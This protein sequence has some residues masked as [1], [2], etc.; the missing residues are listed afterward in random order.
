MITYKDDSLLVPSVG[1][2]TLLSCKPCLFHCLAYF[3]TVLCFC[4]RECLGRIL[5]SKVGSVLLSAKFGLAGLLILHIAPLVLGPAG[6][7]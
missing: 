2:N 1:K 3:H 4:L 6:C 5:E 7:A